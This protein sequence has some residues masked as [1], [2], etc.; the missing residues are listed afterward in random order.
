MTTKAQLVQRL[1]IIGK[2]SQ[3]P[4][5]LL[6]ILPLSPLGFGAVMLSLGV[7]NGIANGPS[8][9][10]R[11]ARIPVQMRAKTL[12]AATTITMLG[13]TIGLVL[14]GI[15]LQALTARTVFVA[16]G[17]LQLASVGLFTAGYINPPN[18]NADNRQVAANRL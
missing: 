8:F 5:F 4:V 6:L 17:V 15:A 9:A 16:M 12:T 11:L 14:A 10:V 7:F 2:S 18:S 3:V 13:A 1:A